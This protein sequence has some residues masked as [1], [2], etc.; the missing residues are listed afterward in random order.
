MMDLNL[1]QVETFGAVGLENA[2]FKQ[3]RSQQIVKC[4]Y[5]SHVTRHTSHVTRHTSHVTRHTSHVTRH[6]SHVTR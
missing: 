6:T 3:W 4:G 2:E 5:M 1:N